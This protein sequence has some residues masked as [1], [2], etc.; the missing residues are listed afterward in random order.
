ME[1]L[2]YDYLNQQRPGKEFPKQSIYKPI[3][4]SEQFKTVIDRPHLI[5]IKKL[6]KHQF[7]TY[8][9]TSLPINHVQMTPAQ[10]K[11]AQKI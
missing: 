2:Q 11:H 5:K 7:K 1:K 6:P 4:F 10:A 3:T 8:I 9:K